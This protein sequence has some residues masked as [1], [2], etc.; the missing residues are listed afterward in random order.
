MH[1]LTQST[2]IVVRTHE[3]SS[4]L[5]QRDGV[6][7]HHHVDH[8]ALKD[9]NYSRNKL[10]LSTDCHRVIVLMGD[11][12]MQCTPLFVNSLKMK[13]LSRKAIWRGI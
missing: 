6:Q 11:V 12:S 5:N 1:C 7:G 10:Y 4:Y 9:Q 3:L 2:I 13:I 8:Q